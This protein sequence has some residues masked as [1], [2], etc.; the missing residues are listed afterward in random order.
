MSSLSNMLR[1]TLL[2]SLYASSTLAESTAN[3]TNDTAVSSSQP[4]S[5]KTR[6]HEQYSG[7]YPLVEDSG[8]T[9]KD[10]H[11]RL[12]FNEIGFSFL[13]RYSISTQ[14]MLY[15][16]NAPNIKVKGQLYEDQKHAVAV[17]ASVNMLLPGTDDFF[18]AFYS[19]RVF[20][21][22][23][24]LYVVP[25]S[26]SHSVRLNKHI[27]LHHSLTDINVYARTDFKTKANIAYST[28]L[29][30]KA[31]QNHSLML[32]GGEVGFWDHDYYLFGLSYRYSGKRFY[33]QMGYFNRVQLEGVQGMPLFDIGFHL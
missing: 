29:Q 7:F 6:E 20:N 32:H 26:L 9:Q 2:L 18:S 13:Q 27:T 31:K 11:W 8:F 33:T 16:A 3:L 22:N 12:G 10:S 14:P 17:T 25:L 28:V 15:A 19:S 30:L 5:I 4:V 21:P 1:L 24:T 23:S